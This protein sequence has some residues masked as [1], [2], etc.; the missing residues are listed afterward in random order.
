M[1]QNPD[2]TFGA[3]D[4]AVVVLM[5]WLWNSMVPEVSDACMFMKTA[6]DVWEN[7][8]QNYSKVGDA[9]QIYE[10]EMKIAITKQGDRSVS[11]CAQTLQNLW[12]ELDHYEQFEAKCTED[13]SLLKR[14]KEKDIIYKFLIGINSEFDLVRI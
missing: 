14:Y 12:L 6:K 8:K 9:A 5:L 7:C 10:I 4:E 2:N 13:A 3:W 1:P 11:E